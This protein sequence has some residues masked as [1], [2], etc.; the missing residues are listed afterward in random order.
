M[1]DHVEHQ[2]APILV[3][4]RHIYCLEHF[5]CLSKKLRT[6]LL[7]CLHLGQSHCIYEHCLVSDLSGLPIDSLGHLHSFFGNGNYLLKFFLCAHS[8]FFE[9]NFHL[10]LL[11]E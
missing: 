1:Q 5:L 9:V 4:D 2:V 11:D 7:S 10:C 3:R 8:E 6:F